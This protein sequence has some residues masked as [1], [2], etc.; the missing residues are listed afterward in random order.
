MKHKI[1]DGNRRSLYTLKTAGFAV[2]AQNRFRLNGSMAARRHD[3][4]HFE[5]K[6][7]SAGTL[8]L[9]EQHA[10]RHSTGTFAGTI[11]IAALQ[12]NLENLTIKVSK[13]EINNRC[14]H[15]WLE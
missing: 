6:R 10:R 8:A 15:M 5:G 14:T 13:I 2:V 1:E 11:N 9:P 4:Y 7:Q 12:P 3:S